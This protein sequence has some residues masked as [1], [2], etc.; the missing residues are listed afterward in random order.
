MKYLWLAVSPDKYE[1]P[2]VVED[3][4]KKLARRL[5][6]S[7]NVVSSSISKNLSGKIQGRKIIKVQIEE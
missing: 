4:A 5:N 2:M 6:V 1:L 7:S 3:S